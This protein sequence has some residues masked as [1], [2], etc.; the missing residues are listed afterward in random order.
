MRKRHVHLFLLPAFVIIPLT[1]CRSMKLKP[2]TICGTWRHYGVDARNGKEIPFDEG[3]YTIF[4]PDGICR[5]EIRKPRLERYPGKWR[6][7]G[8]KVELRDEKGNSIRWQYDPIS[9]KMSHTAY[10]KTFFPRGVKLI[11]I[12][13][14]EKP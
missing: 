1:G 8:E 7:I 10:E 3:L 9:C 11:L 2:E 13:E 4:L 12:K 5:N 6:I 14:P